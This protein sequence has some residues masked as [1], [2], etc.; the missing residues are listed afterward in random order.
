M[1]VSVVLPDQLRGLVPDGSNV[2]LPGDP[3]TVREALET[4]RR[5]HLEVY[6]RIV[7]E[8]GE[9]RPHVNLFV[10]R[11]NIR[12]HEGLETRLPEGAELVVL[13]AV[14]GG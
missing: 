3:G 11:E 14:S 1:S 13:P 2:C 10:G 12:W 8:Q 9:V 7:T 5:H 6:H 4:L